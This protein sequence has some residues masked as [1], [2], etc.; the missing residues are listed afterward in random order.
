LSLI[1]DFSEQVDF[2][3][4]GAKI[5]IYIFSGY[6]PLEWTKIFS[7]IYPHIVKFFYYGEPYNAN[8]LFLI[9]RTSPPPEGTGIVLVDTN[10]LSLTKLALR[11]LSYSWSRGRKA[12]LI[13]PRRVSAHFY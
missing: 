7:R 5:Q 9:Y 1:L 13:S 4:G 2:Y 12:S 8:L 10:D 6:A 3:I 11:P